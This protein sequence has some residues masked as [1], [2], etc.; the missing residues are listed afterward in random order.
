MKNLVF[1][2]SFMGLICSL[3]LSSQ[4]FAGNAGNGPSNSGTASVTGCDRSY[5]GSTL[6]FSD[7]EVDRLYREQLKAIRW[8][9]ENR[10]NSKVVPLNGPVG[11]LSAKEWR[12]YNPRLLVPKFVVFDQDGC[13]KSE[14]DGMPSEEGLGVKFKD[15]E[16]RVSY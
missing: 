2:R 5:S 16:G 8:A 3:A 1:S 9:L 14:F 12:S 4:V 7:S 6:I 15:V 13:V 11:V 10:A